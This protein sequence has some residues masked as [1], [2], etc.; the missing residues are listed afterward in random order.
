VV[1]WCVWPAAHQVPAALLDV[2][3]LHAARRET[4]SVCSIPESRGPTTNCVRTRAHTPHTTHTHTHT[5]TQIR[6]ANCRTVLR[7]LGAPPGKEGGQGWSA[8]GGQ[9]PPPPGARPR[10]RPVASQ[11]PRWRPESGA[12]WWPDGSPVATPIA[13]P[14]ES[15]SAAATPLWAWASCPTA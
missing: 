10:P 8:G 5:H 13:L 4:E 7:Q 11:Q 9:T 12:P 3:R 6:G 14:S 1:L 15:G 2:W